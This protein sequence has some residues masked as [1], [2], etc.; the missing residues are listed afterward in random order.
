M[1]AVRALLVIFPDSEK[2]LVKLSQDLVTKLV[3]FIYHRKPFSTAG[4][5]FYYIMLTFSMFAR[6]FAIAEE[7]VKTR[8]HPADLLGVLGKE[9]SFATFTIFG[10]ILVCFLVLRLVPH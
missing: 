10:H 9:Y 8:I 4:N 1:E 7:Y 6:N 5:F 3:F 2:Q